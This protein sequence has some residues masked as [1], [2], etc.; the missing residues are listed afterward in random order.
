MAE[1]LLLPI[2]GPIEL[3]QAAK[4]E[5][6]K[7]P[8]HLWSLSKDMEPKDAD[9]VHLSFDDFIKFH[10]E[11]PCL[12]GSVGDRILIHW[13]WTPSVRK[14]RAEGIKHIIEFFEDVDDDYKDGV[15][16]SPSVEDKNAF[17][18]YAEHDYIVL[19][20]QKLNNGFHSRIIKVFVTSEDEPRI[21]KFL[22]LMQ[23]HFLEIEYPISLD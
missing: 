3:L 4:Q 15:L 18:L 10:G 1:E 8:P 2:A 7:N 11:N 5:E 12:S 9:L 22:K 14:A 13:Q 16:S 6:S 17:C 20:F 23:E 21:K 19:V